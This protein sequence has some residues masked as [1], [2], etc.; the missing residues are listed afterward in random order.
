MSLLLSPTLF[1]LDPAWYDPKN[2]RED[3]PLPGG[4]DPPKLII[5]ISPHAH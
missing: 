4:E 3:L 1:L 5:F 2:D